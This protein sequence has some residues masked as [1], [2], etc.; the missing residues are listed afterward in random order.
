MVIWI[1][2]SGYA[3]ASPEKVTILALGDSLTEG[4]QLNKKDAYPAQLE[5]LLKEKGY[6]GIHILNHGIS[7]DT[8]AGGRA[9]IQ[10]AI[11]A[12]PDIIIVALG[13]NDFLRGLPPSST[14]DN[15]EYIVKTL[16]EAD[17]D[18]ILVGFNAA[19]NIGPVFQEQFDAIFPD[20]EA[21]Y[22]ITVTYTFLTGVAGDSNLNLDD[23]IHPNADGYNIVAQN[24]LPT[25]KT[26]IHQRVLI[27]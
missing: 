14:R 16:T 17:I 22:P 10:R 27:Q 12:A 3:I 2:S 26:V 21:A 7:G 20:L 6:A 4:Y 24:L 19:P 13:P 23:G 15:L 25:V 11:D 9:R 18:V 8:T 1:A 5:R